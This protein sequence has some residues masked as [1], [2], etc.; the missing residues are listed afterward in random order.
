MKK[1]VLDIHDLQQ[2]APVFKKKWA[3]FFGKRLMKWLNIGKVN[4]IHARYSHLSGAE[5][6]SAILADPMMD[7][8][9][10]VH[11]PERL[12][13]L[14]E[15]AFITVSNHPIGSL[16][17][18]VLIDL[19]ASR[20]KDF[21]VMVN[22]ILEKIGAM[23]DNFIAVTPRTGGQTETNPANV[24]GVRASLERLKNG[25]PMGFFPA[26]AMSF[27]SK[28]GTIRDLPWTHN[29][30]RLIRKAGVP[31]Y[32]VYFDCRNSKFFYWLGQISWKIRLLRV[33][34]EAFNKQGQTL[35]VHIG[36]PIAPETIRSYTDDKAL[37]DFLYRTTYGQKA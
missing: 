7:V 3:A 31:V 36:Q 13:T 28:D 32:P 21:C 33:P 29:V 4:T 17:G 26:G 35:D 20:R 22:G 6:T 27:C 24:N 14:P 34:T 16:D 15:G 30:I 2:F 23:A 9:Y 1:T 8:K 18:I 5:F 19:F 37:A 12:K 11:H 10:K 25:H